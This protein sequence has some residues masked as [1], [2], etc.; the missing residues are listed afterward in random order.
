MT[1]AN[2]ITLWLR[3]AAIRIMDEDHLQIEALYRHV[4]FAAD[5]LRHVGLEGVS[6]DKLTIR[7]QSAA[8]CVRW[9]RNACLWRVYDN[10]T[11]EDI[12]GARAT[13]EYIVRRLDEAKEPD[14]LTPWR[15]ADGSQLTRAQ[16]RAWC[17]A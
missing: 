13:A 5:R 8:R 6:A 12:F 11:G 1:L 17:R 15:Y 14:E 10:Q 4:R 7:I 3:A 2:E 9:D 16:L